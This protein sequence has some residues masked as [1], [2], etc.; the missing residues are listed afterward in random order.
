[1]E[2]HR[3]INK[4]QSGLIDLAFNNER[5]KQSLIEFWVG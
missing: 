5:E 4:Q 2:I 3:E 1:L